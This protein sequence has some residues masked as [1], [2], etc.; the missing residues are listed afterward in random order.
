MWYPMWAENQ[1]VSTGTELTKLIKEKLDQMP[2]VSVSVPVPTLPA[3]NAPAV[4]DVV[5]AGTRD[6][7]KAWKCLVVGKTEAIGEYL[8][9][10]GVDSAEF[11]DDMEESELLELA[12]L[13]AVVKKRAFL[14]AMNINQ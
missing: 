3:A 13:L 1:I 14:K 10:L 11:L 12:E 2:S 4:A 5:A 6:L 7:E 8:A 9:K